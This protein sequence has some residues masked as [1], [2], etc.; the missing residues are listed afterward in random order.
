L[1]HIMKLKIFNVIRKSKVNNGFTE[2]D[3]SKQNC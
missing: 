3:T 2:D 1:L